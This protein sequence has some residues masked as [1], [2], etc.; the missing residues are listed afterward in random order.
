M[1][2]LLLIS[3]LPAVSILL[4]LL[5][6][7]SCR[8]AYR[9]ITLGTTLLQG[10]MVGIVLASFYNHPS[11]EE[12]WTVHRPWMQLN[13][14]SWGRLAVDYLVGVDGLNVG[15][16]GLTALILNVGVIASWN[17]EQYAKG[18]FIL[19]LLI[20]MLVVGSFLALDFLLFYIFFEA[21]L[22]P[23]YFFLGIWGGKGGKQAA[24]Q[25]FLYTLSGTLLILLVLIGLGQSVYDPVATG[26]QAGLLHAGEVLTPAK[27]ETVQ[28]A[29]QHYAINSTDI[30]HS[31]RIAHMQDVHNF[32]PDAALGLYSGKLMGGHAAR[33]WAFGAL[34]LGFCI[35]LAAVPL[36]TWLPDAH[37]EAPT[38]ISIILAALLLKIGAYGLLRIAYNIF[39]E[40]AIY[41]SKGIGVL[42]LLSI[43]YAALNALAMQ[44]IKR[45]VAYASIAHMG[46]V[47]LGL[48][49]LTCE[50]I[51]GALY[52]LVSHG[53][54]ATLLFLIAGV[55]QDRTG[56]RRIECY[57]GLTH[58]MPRYAAVA[59]TTFFAALGLPGF[60]GFIGELLVLLGAF[61]ATKAGYP[62]WL[63]IVGTLGVLLN[64]IYWVWTMQRMFLG[65]FALRGS[66][67]EGQ[68]YDLRTREYVML[69]P[70]LILILLLGIFPHW[71]LGLTQDAVSE[72]VTRIHTVGR[73][74]LEAILS[75]RR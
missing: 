15:L 51:Q 35:K 29:V 47:L 27:I 3:W 55:L 21:A 25:F 41:Y 2:V 12:I 8:Q 52:Q 17:V 5:L 43:T 20:N 61:Q 49:S 33:L 28:Q 72:L 39:P 58:K 36:H 22:L 75:W 31:L 1:L 62:L 14:G 64:A 34:V 46:F 69:V 45:M 73:D 70:L 54:L 44:D 71:L 53:L 10:L 7:T 4:L 68:L 9:Y 13:M 56:E 48:G 67:K 37:V 19:Y 63:G 24:T 30:V 32:L 6:P 42:G 59:T 16:L 18:Y 66:A 50:G 11:G 74:N 23:I 65:S 40:G 60:S 26:L 38:P 57:S